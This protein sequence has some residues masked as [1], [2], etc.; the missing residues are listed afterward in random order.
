MIPPAIARLPASAGQLRQRLI[1]WTAINSGSDHLAGLARMAAVLREACRE[2]TAQVDLVPLD[3][4]GR[5]AIR[6][7]LRPDAHLQILCSGHYDTVYG[8]AHPFQQTREI[9]AGRLNGPGVAD[10]KGGIVVMLAALAA[11]EQTPHA[12]RLGWEILLTPDEETGSQASRALI[13]ASAPRFDAALIFEPARE[14]GDLVRSRKGTGIFTLTCHGREAHAGRNPQEGRNAIVALA[15]VLLGVHRLPDG[16]PDLMLNIG[17]IHGGGAV[18]IVP[19]LASAE[20]NVRIGRAETA[21]LFHERLQALLAPINAREGY[22]LEVTGG[23][24]RLPM[25]A[26]LVS[27][28]L[29]EAWQ[30]CAHDLGEPPFSWVHV[31]GGSDGNLLSAVGLPCIDGVGVIGGE[32]HSAREWVDFTRLPGRAQMAALALHRIAAGEVTLPSRR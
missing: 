25:E 7:R 16:L 23:F 4:D 28:Q 17:S 15:E 29:F 2:L 13:E 32:L 31:G 20:I 14:S 19:A 1:D 6:A 27:T 24:N 3:A 9:D 21:T 5:V 11:F 8:A 30:A 22:R 12:S 18:N 10:M 26:G